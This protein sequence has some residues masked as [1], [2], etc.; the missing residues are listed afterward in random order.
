MLK[1]M[2]NRQNSLN[3]RKTL[4]NSNAGSSARLENNSSVIA[5]LM[6]FDQTPHRGQTVSG[7]QK[8]LSENYIQKS[9]SVGKRSRRDSQNYQL[10]SKKRTNMRTNDSSNNNLLREL[11]EKR[12]RFDGMQGM[13]SPIVSELVKEVD[14]G[15]LYSKIR[16]NLANVG[17][18][19]GP[20]FLLDS[21]TVFA[22]EVK[23][24]L[25][26]RIKMNKGSLELVSNFRSSLGIRSNGG[27]KYESATKIP[28]LECLNF[29]SKSNTKPVKMTR[30]NVKPSVRKLVNGMSTN[31]KKNNAGPQEGELF[32]GDTKD[33][34]NH[35]AKEVRSDHLSDLSSEQVSFSMSYSQKFFV[36]CGI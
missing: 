22:W 20:S 30:S 32:H 6:G 34:G 19:S 2:E 3:I 14:D 15:K 35:S 17:Y 1:V 7:P 23:K 36:Y 11:E 24:Q 26:E 25:L 13:N 28:I 21:Q 9:D 16:P 27:R 5:K 31:A 4:I 10:R 8:V 33:K 18:A 29:F 12:S